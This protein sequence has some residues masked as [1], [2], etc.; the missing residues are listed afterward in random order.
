[1]RETSPRNSTASI[2]SLGVSVS[3]ESV[4]IGGC[5]I[6]SLARSASHV[7]PGGVCPGYPF[8]LFV[9][10]GISNFILAYQKYELPVRGMKT[11]E[12]GMKHFQCLPSERATNSDAW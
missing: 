3:L 11:P 5:V 9:P 8:P 1:M 10:L 2:T 6:P 12:T 7:I 4:V